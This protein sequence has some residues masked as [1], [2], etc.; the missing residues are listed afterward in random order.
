MASLSDETDRQFTITSYVNTPA[1]QAVLV[2]RLGW[3]SWCRGRSSVYS[4]MSSQSCW[5][6]VFL[7][8][9]PLLLKNWS[10]EVQQQTSA[11]PFLGPPG[12][13]LLFCFKVWCFAGYGTSLLWRWPSNR[14]GVPSSA[15]SVV[16]LTLLFS[17]LQGTVQPRGRVLKIFS[18]IEFFLTQTV[19]VYSLL[20][21][22]S[23]LNCWL[24]IIG[25]MCSPLFLS[26]WPI[27]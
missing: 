24:L 21:S 20:A 11:W 17:A 25:G 14:A 16:W 15:I 3:E 4:G 13:P 22:W 9:F 12:P 2:P 18:Q 26:H 27:Q 19:S 1:P 23:F 8:P 10:V 7:W 5:A 6:P